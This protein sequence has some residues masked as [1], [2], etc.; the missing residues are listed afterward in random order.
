MNRVLDECSHY[1]GPEWHVFSQRKRDME[2][3]VRE[4]G[5]SV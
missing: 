4:E 2:K 5:W 3:Q 1:L